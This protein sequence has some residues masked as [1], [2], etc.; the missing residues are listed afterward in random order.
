[1]GASPLL[2]AQVHAEDEVEEE[3]VVEDEEAQEDST[4]D[5][6]LDESLK[7]VSPDAE[8]TLL[9]TK[10]AQAPGGSV[11]LPAGKIVEFLVGFSNNGDSDFVVD[12]LEASFRYPMD[13]T[14]HIQNFSAITYQKTVKPDQEAT[15]AYSFIPADAFAGRPI[16]LIVNLAYRDLEGNFFMDPVFNETVQIVEFD[17]GF[18]SEV[19]FMY[20]FL[21]AGAFLVLFLVYTILSKSVKSSKKSGGVARKPVETGTSNSDVDFEW[22]PRSAVLAQKTPGSNKTSPRQRKGKRGA[23]NASD[24]E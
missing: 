3:T 20:V 4:V 12:S 17:E 13:F 14:Y 23:A 19:F 11:E 16:G 24:T 21:V 10:P 7:N 1:M 8:T 6:D 22:I 15:V 18:D 2:F 5:E 9:F